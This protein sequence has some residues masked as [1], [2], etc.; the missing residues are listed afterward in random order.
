MGYS[1]SKMGRHKVCKYTHNN[2][3]YLYTMYPN[4]K[5]YRTPT[6]EQLSLLVERGFELSAPTS[7]LTETISEQ[8]LNS[9]SDDFWE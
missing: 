8:D 6:L 3:Q 2:Q 1:P 5:P 4:L 7:T 9:S